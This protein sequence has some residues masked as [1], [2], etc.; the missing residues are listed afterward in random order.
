MAAETRSI[1]TIT[2]SEKK[3]L[4]SLLT[5]KGRKKESKFLAEGVRL[6]EEAVR[7]GWT[8]EI[9]YYSESILS[10]RGRKLVDKI[11]GAGAD[12]RKIAACDIEA[13]TGTQTSP[14]IIGVFNIPEYNAVELM[15]GSKMILLM[16]GISDPGNAGT[17]LRSGAA[18]GFDMVF[19]V[20]D[21]VEP[22]NPKVV[23][24][25]AG[26]IFGIPVIEA[27]TGDI[28]RY[29]NDGE[30]LLM[31][32]DLA[33]SNLEKGLRCLKRNSKVILAVGSEAD[34]L[35]KPVAD[36]ADIK[37]SVGH[38]NKVESLNAA[39]AGSIIMMSIYNK[40][41]EKKR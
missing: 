12:V 35:S 7:H 29:K 14:G 36:M 5:K 22:Y 19:M 28:L 21:A 27:T 10:E 15:P 20:N 4:R 2:S 34:G 31:A 1:K 18:F 24:S 38:S 6:L 32:A 3:K 33:G 11:N 17:L 23:R 16:D 9:I 26:A 25:S 8:P 13:V 40:G 37:V 39:V 30:Y 41:I